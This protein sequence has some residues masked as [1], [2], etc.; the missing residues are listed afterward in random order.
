MIL[1]LKCNVLCLESASSISC[2]LFSPAFFL[3]FLLHPKNEFSPLSFSP[4]RI[5]LINRVVC[6]QYMCFYVRAWPAL[7]FYCTTIPCNTM[8]DRIP[9]FK[10]EV[11]TV[12]RLRIKLYKYS[13]AIPVF[14]GTVLWASFLGQAS[15]IH[16]LQ[17]IVHT[18]Y[19]STHM[20]CPLLVHFCISQKLSSLSFSALQYVHTCN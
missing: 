9:Y 2:I 5:L 19:V 20:Y 15:H 11:T 8:L 13:N 4:S 12:N 18:T 10:S 7:P 17:Y 16:L 6:V 1:Y 14:N 3:S